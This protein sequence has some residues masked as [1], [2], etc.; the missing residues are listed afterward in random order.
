MQTQISDLDEPCRKRVSINVDADRVEKQFRQSFAELRNTVSL[1][2][3]RR[4]KVPISMLQKH[5]WPSR[6]VCQSWS[7]DCWSPRANT[8][9]RCRTSSAMQSRANGPV[10]PGLPGP[11][12]SPAPRAWQ[13]WA[14]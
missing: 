13:T 7:A 2:G 4:G 6:T 11:C 10:P 8:I 3:F 1:P 5:Y 14:W 9:T 12:A